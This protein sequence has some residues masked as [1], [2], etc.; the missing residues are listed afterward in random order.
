MEATC[1]SAPSVLPR[2]PMMRP[3]L[4]LSTRMS[5]RTLPASISSRIRA[6]TLFL[7]EVSGQSPASTMSMWTRGEYPRGPPAGR[8]LSFGLG[9]GNRLIHPAGTPPRSRGLDLAGAT[10]A[11]GRA[12]PSGRRKT[13]STQKRELAHDWPVCGVQ[14]PHIALQRTPRFRQPR[15]E[16]QNGARPAEGRSCWRSSPSAL[17]KVETAFPCS[18]C[19]F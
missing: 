19:A 15:H 7:V 6:P 11:F 5:C 10:F 16:P 9:A 8:V 1:S 2:W 12:W 18:W 4:L 14:K 13:D 17:R 3:T